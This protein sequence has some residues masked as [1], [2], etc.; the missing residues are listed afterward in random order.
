MKVRT[1]LIDLLVVCGIG[2]CGHRHGRR[3]AGGSAR[4]LQD[5]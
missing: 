1:S 4:G 2:V 5:L 3:A